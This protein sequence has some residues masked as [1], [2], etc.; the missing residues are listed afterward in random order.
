MSMHNN[1]H[2]LHTDWKL[3]VT[4]IRPC[5]AGVVGTNWTNYSLP[6][7][8]IPLV[9]SAASMGKMECQIGLPQ[10]TMRRRSRNLLAEPSTAGARHNAS[11]Q[12]DLQGYGSDTSGARGVVRRLQRSRREA[13]G[14]HRSLIPRRTAQAAQPIADGP[15][16]PWFMAAHIFAEAGWYRVIAQTASDRGNQLVNMAW[17]VQVKPNELMLKS[18]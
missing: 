12:R 4:K 15:F 16:G 14:A 6:L 11:D 18:K 9:V 17:W 5:Y 10:Q 1:L 8:G 2:Y 13:V 7:L 3:L